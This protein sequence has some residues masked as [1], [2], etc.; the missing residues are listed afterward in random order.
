MSTP[1]LLI[2][3]GRARMS[4]HEPVSTPASTFLLVSYVVTSPSGFYSIIVDIDTK[5]VSAIYEE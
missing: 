5:I 1:K 2:K 3:A 4:N